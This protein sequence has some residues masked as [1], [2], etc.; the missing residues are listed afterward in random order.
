[1]SWTGE[2]QQGTDN[3]AADAASAKGLSMTPAVATVLSPFFAFMRQFQIFP[4]MI[5]VPGH[6]VLTH[7]MKG[8]RSPPCPMILCRAAIAFRLRFVRQCLRPTRYSELEMPDWSVN[9]KKQKIR[10]DVMAMAS[11]ET[12]IRETDGLMYTGLD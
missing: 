11:F 3:S 5:H 4:N 8:L 10:N 12:E 1:M 9:G 7:L 2:C 6:L